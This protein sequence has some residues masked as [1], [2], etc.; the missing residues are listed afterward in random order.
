MGVEVCCASLYYQATR[1]ISCK[2]Q[3]AVD[4]HSQ[5]SAQEPAFFCMQQLQIQNQNH[6][7]CVDT[8]LEHTVCLSICP[9][10]KRQACQVFLMPPPAVNKQQVCISSPLAWHSSCSSQQFISNDMQLHI[11]SLGFT[12]LHVLHS[13]Q[14][15]HA[16]RWRAC[17]ICDYFVHAFHSMVG[18]CACTCM[19]F[20]HC[21]VYVQHR[22][23]IT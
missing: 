12:S 14:S 8:L 13:I 21:T 17:V 9:D 20:R 19:V 22:A 15:Q 3:K 6:E 5:R 23:A 4:L 2:T 18:S 10:L 16:N 1:N 7:R 11:R